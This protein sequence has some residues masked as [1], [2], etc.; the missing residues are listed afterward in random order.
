[1]ITCDTAPVRHI[2]GGTNLPPSLTSLHVAYCWASA[3]LG[4]GALGTLTELRRLRVV[5]CGRRNLTPPWLTRLV[6]LE[7]YVVEECVHIP[8]WWC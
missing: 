8:E 7:E 6:N 2:D 1:M 4:E 3:P 5:S